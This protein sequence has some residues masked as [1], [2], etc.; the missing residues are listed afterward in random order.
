MKYNTFIYICI[1]IYTHAYK[2]YLIQE[3]S[4]VYLARPGWTTVASRAPGRQQPGPRSRRGD[5]M[6]LGTRR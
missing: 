5:A 4:V 3:A 2:R 1:Y 6:P